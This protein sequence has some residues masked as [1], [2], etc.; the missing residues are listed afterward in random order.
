MKLGSSLR[1]SRGGG[2]KPNRKR[3]KGS[4]SRRSS[5]AGSGPLLRT[6]LIALGVATIGGGSGWLFATEVLYPAP[7][8]P[9]DLRE[10]PD[11]SGRA[12][13]DALAALADAGLESGAIAVIRHPRVDS[14]AVI[15]Q[16]PLPGQLALPG[17]IVELTVSA[18]PE[19]RSIPDVMRLRGDR[20]AEL[21]RATGFQVRVDSAESRLPRGRI[22]VVDPAPG[23]QLALPGEVHITVSVG[24]RTIV[25]PY[26]LG[27]EE[28]E[29]RDTLVALGLR[30]GDVEEVFRFGRDQGRVV[31]QSPVEGVEVDRGA[32]V[33]LVVGRRGGNAPER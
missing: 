26:L 30:L 11:L 15:G 19:R 32:E 12:Q 5:S 27:L 4:R 8:P 29:A 24:P 20:A 1:R 13:D 21:L 31:E 22:M 7:A 18:G 16:S 25:V 9:E 2:S 3:S 33:K 10:V 28:A 23:A 17:A 6:L 14:G